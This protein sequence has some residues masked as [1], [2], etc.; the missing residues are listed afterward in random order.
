M[1][2]NCTLVFWVR[3]QASELPVAA[4]T[5]TVLTDFILQRPAAA[6]LLVLFMLAFQGDLF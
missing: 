5:Q 4:P 2:Q 1:L 3:K 6:A